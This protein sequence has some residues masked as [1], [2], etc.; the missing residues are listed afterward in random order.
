MQRDG[1]PNSDSA[2]SC[3]HHYN[4]AVSEFGAPIKWQ[5]LRTARVAVL[6]DAEILGPRG[7]AALP[8]EGRNRRCHPFPLSRFH[9]FRFSPLHQPH[10]LR[11]RLPLRVPSDRVV[12]HGAHLGEPPGGAFDARLAVRGGRGATLAVEAEFQ[13]TGAVRVVVRIHPRSFAWG[14]GQIRGWRKERLSGLYRPGEDG[15][16][17]VFSPVRGRVTHKQRMSDEPTV[18]Q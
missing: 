15:C 3:E 7:S 1:A 2:R 17:F 14:V 4:R 18:Q 11:M 10:L 6:A 16:E 12:H 5:W 9:A 13:L 8:D